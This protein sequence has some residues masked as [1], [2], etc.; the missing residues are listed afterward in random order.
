MSVT[1]LC[2]IDVSLSVWMMLSGYFW[3]GYTQYNLISILC[4]HPMPFN[5]FMLNHPLNV[6]FVFR[7]ISLQLS[8]S[9]GIFLLSIT[10]HTI[11]V[12]HV[13]LFCP[14]IHISVQVKG[15]YLSISIVFV[16]FFSLLFFL[17]TIFLTLELLLSVGSIQFVLSYLILLCC[18]LYCLI[19]WSQIGVQG[20]VRDFQIHSFKLKKIK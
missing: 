9:Q 2:V 20:S 5:V 13:W 6:L 8:I 3:Y 18:S 14:I 16:Q 15:T 10:L 12:Q 11:C 17:P 4:N 19:Q 7:Q 1:P